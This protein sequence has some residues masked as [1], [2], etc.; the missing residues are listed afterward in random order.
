M[1]EKAFPSSTT[2]ETGLGLT[3]VYNEGMDLR[4]Y[5]AAKAMQGLIPLFHKAMSSDSKTCAEWSYEMADQMIE[6]RKNGK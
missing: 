4:D 5:F 1:K 6:A 2:E 3:D